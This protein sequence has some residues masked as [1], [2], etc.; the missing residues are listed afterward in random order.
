MEPSERSEAIAA[1]RAVASSLGLA[2]DDAVVLRDSN[3][4]TL[5]LVPSDTLARVAPAVAN[6]AQF[7]VD[8][9]LALAQAGCPVATLDPRVPPRVY[10]RDSFVITLWTYYEPTA[11]EISPVEYASALAR[12]HA[13]MRQS[14]APA[15][16]FTERVESAGRLVASRERTPELVDADRH[17]LGGILRDV[18]YA[19][20]QRGGEQL[21]HGEPHPGNLLATKNGPMFIDFETCC[22]GPVEFDVAHAPDQVA[23]RYPGLDREL[24]RD[25]RTLTLAMITTWRWDRDDQ[26]PDGRRLGREWLDQLRVAAARR[27]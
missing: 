26:L 18:G 6:A 21:L 20:A 3:K 14:D 13:G 25:C 8:I 15:P 19:V 17:L 5:R 24:L 11:G 9:S 2:V 7:E 23:V 16:H 1:A 4:L 10:A 22:R 27:E 12:L